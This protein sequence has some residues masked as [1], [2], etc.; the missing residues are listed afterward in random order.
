MNPWVLMT[1]VYSF[2]IIYQFFFLCKK[3]KCNVNSLCT[4]RVEM[5][6]QNQYFKFHFAKVIGKK[7][8]DEF[9]SI[10]SSIWL[11]QF[12]IMF[13]RCMLILYSCQYMTYAS[14]LLNCLCGYLLVALFIFLCKNCVITLQETNKKFGILAKIIIQGDN[15][16][17]CM[18]IY[19]VQT[20]FVET[21]FASKQVLLIIPFVKR[22]IRVDLLINK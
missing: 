12:V 22:C 18:I 16:G 2:V 5:L 3:V 17:V 4:L 8:R 1:C 14:F 11:A 13:T 6:Q 9:F 15:S 21:I 10:S 20:T 19:G 7:T